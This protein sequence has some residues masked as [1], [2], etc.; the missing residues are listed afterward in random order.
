MPI[1]HK[2]RENAIGVFVICRLSIAESC[3]LRDNLLP[4]P[5]RGRLNFFGIAHPVLNGK[6][7]FSLEQG[8]IRNSSLGIVARLRV[9]SV[10]Y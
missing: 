2:L 7:R 8:T 4:I 3:G 9:L 6:F 10:L 1:F 5:H